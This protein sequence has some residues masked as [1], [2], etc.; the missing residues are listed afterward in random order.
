MT[1]TQYMQFF[2]WREGGLNPTAKKNQIPEDDTIGLALSVYEIKN[3]T[4]HMLEQFDMK[5][6]DA[7]C[8]IS[9]MNFR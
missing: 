3:P 6:V 8:Q 5:P 2:H 4:Q 7:F 9:L 1:L